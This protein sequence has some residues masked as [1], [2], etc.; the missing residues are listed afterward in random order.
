MKRLTLDLQ[1]S[2]KSI[3]YQQFLNQKII[4]ESYVVNKCIAKI[5]VG[6]LTL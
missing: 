4:L 1:W 2:A 3:T 6:L 5:K